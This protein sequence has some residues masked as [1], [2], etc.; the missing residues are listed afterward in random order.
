MEPA[1]QSLIDRLDR[2]SDGFQELREGVQ[3]AV[4]IADPDPEMALIR[5]RKVL[6]YVVRDVFERRVKEPPGTRPLEGL[7]Q[8]LVKDGHLPPRLAAY[9]ETIR[10]LGNVGAHRFGQ[11]ITAATSI[12]RSAHC[13]RSS[14]GTLKRNIPAQLE[15]VPQPPG[16]PPNGSYPQ[17]RLGAAPIN[18]ASPLFRRACGRST[19]TTATSSCNC[20]PGPR[21]GRPAR[22][23]PVLEAPD[24]GRPPS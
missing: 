21:P 8:R 18:P 9:T 13:C 10:E 17:N 11:K 1:L 19:P 14:N 15:M 6:E 24:R 22:E 5:A 7:I 16:K 20:C 23:H 2:L 4:R 12:D 3:K